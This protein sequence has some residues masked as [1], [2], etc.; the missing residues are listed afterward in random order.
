MLKTAK[1]DQN[2]CWTTLGKGFHNL[3]DSA[4]QMNNLSNAAVATNEYANN[5][6]T[7][8]KALYRYERIV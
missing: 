4:K 7:A 8:S 6:K 1:F 5:V 3:A 2:L